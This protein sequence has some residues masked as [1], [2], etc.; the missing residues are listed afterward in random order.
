MLLL[1]QYRTVEDAYAQTGSAHALEEME[2]QG[3]EQTDWLRLLG[4]AAGTLVVGPLSLYLR[5]GRFHLGGGSSGGVRE[6]GNRP[7]P[8]HAIRL[9]ESTPIVLPRRELWWK[10]G[11]MTLTCL[12]CGYFV[13]A[14]TPRTGRFEYEDFMFRRVTSN[15]SLDRT[16][17]FNR[18]VSLGN[19]GE[20]LDDQ[21]IVLEAK[22]QDLESE[23]LL[24]IQGDLYFRGVVLNQYANGSWD[25]QM[26]TGHESP[27]RLRP[28]GLVTK[29]GLVRQ[30]VT[31]QPLDEPDLFGIWP[32]LLE[33]ED[34]LEWF[35][36]GEQRLFRPYRFRQRKFTYQMVT[37]AFQGRMQAEFVPAMGSIDPKPLLAMPERSLRY[38]AS[39]AEEWVR[40]SRVST[41]DPVGCARVLERGLGSSADF[42][43]STRGVER[44]ENLDPIEDFVKYRRQGHCEYFA[45]ALALMLRSR[46]LPARLVVGFKT[47]ERREDKQ[48]AVA[49]QGHA[50]AWVEM[51]LAPEQVPAAVRA[52]RPSDWSQGGWM[53]LDPTPVS[54]GDSAEG[55]LSV[56]H[57]WVREVREAW[58]DHVLRMNRARQQRSLYGPV[59]DWIRDSLSQLTEREWWETVVWARLRTWFKNPGQL[60]VD[61]GRAWRWIVFLVMVGVAGVLLRELLRWRRERGRGPRKGRG[62]AV[63]SVPRVEFYRRL[64]RL[65]GSTGLRRGLAQTPR[66]YARDGADRLAESSGESELVPQARL[67]V[68]A[69]YQLRFGGVRL[70]PEQTESVEQALQQIRRATRRRV[71]G[72]G[73][74]PP[75]SK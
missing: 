74:S 69:F 12:V 50:H 51:Y 60:V 72:N 19:E 43:Y 21:Q 9:E 66:E 35:D 45:S 61:V 27:A 8:Q 2:M 28:D 47:S 41:D 34:Q 63:V 32:Y 38:L 31:V 6:H 10:V 20:L 52:E 56:L 25:R 57:R 7:D 29:R 64:E 16:V 44:L 58:T 54:A 24:D 67:V 73:H 55:L 4:I 75:S 1:H 3:A 30:L 48:T 11:G 68:D 62:R 17:G 23:T 65:L 13:F 18:D 42:E 49:R 36:R 46:G 33:S 37:N 26:Y 39:L 15:Q 59:T 14:F 71:A 70:Q 53:R 5:F 40:N 22:F